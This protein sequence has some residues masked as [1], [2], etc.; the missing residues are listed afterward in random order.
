MRFEIP[1]PTPTL[2]EWQRMHWAKR[3][4]VAKGFAWMVR[5]A[6]GPIKVKPMQK[7]KVRIERHSAGTPDTDGLYGGLKPL[8]DCLVVCT[9]RNPHGLGL[10]QDDNPGCMQLE[11]VSVKCKQKEGKTVIEITDG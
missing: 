6:L 9:K 10:V 8:L 3:G 2:N 5:A 7:C 11:A 4:R 1:E